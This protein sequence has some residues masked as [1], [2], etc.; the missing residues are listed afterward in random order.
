MWY[1]P[2]LVAIAYCIKLGFTV[3]AVVYG[4]KYL[5]EFAFNF[6]TEDMEKKTK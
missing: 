3:F 4:L 6:L 1:E 5:A 2:F